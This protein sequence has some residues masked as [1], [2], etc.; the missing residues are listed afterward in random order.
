MGVNEIKTWGGRRTGAG[1]KKDPNSYRSRAARRKAEIAPGVF[2]REFEIRV[3][4][5][6]PADRAAN[7]TLVAI[8]YGDAITLPERILSAAEADEKHA[9]QAQKSGCGERQLETPVKVKGVGLPRRLDRHAIFVKPMLKKQDPSPVGRPLVRT[10]VTASDTAPIGSLEGCAGIPFV[11]PVCQPRDCAFM[12][13]F[14]RAFHMPG[15]LFYG[16]QPTE[17]EPVVA[18]PDKTVQLTQRERAELL[19][20]DEARKQAGHEVQLAMDEAAAEQAR[21]KLLQA[22]G[23]GA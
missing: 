1:R 7:E 5:I 4:P 11:N 6:T 14:Q 2:L 9:D 3:V 22:T 21:K 17:Y 16:G 18:W 19:R 20:E 10:S 13:G 8:K 15:P 12:S 23:Y